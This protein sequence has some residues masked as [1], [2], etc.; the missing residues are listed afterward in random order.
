MSDLPA[1]DEVIAV[2]ASDLHLSHKRPSCRDEEDWYAVM[3]GYLGEMYDLAGKHNVPVIVAGDLFHTWYEPAQVISFA[4]GRIL[5]TTYAIPGQHD[6]PYHSNE[7]KYRSAYWTLVEAGKIKDLSS[8]INYPEVIKGAR[9]YGFPYGFDVRPNEQG[10]TKPFALNVAV[11]HKYVWVKDHGHLK[12]KEEDRLKNWGKVLKGYD[13]AVC[14]D[15]HQ[16]FLAKTGDCVFFNCGTFMRRRADEISYRPQVGLLRANGTVER[17][18]LDTSEDVFSDRKTKKE[19]VAYDGTEFLDEL[20][21]LG[22]AA[23]SFSDAME[24]AVGGGEVDPGVRELI[25][26]AMEKN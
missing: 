11:I 16:G 9:L 23:I 19:G 3:D 4:I 2:L 5:C 24:R 12:A 21:K 25:L 22:E 14:G 6:L 26:K 13:V 17:V 1:P 7:H 18:Y 10:S 20:S 15:N 8:N